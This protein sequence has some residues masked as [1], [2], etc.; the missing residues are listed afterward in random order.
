MSNIILTKNFIKKACKLALHE[1]LHP[2]GDITSNLLK[3][4][5]NKK[6]KLIT[7]EPGIIAG[8]EFFKQTFNI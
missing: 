4:N 2:S 6:I 8:L 1:D 5:V 3:N 7:N